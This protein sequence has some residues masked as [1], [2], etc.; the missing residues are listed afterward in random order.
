MIKKQRTQIDGLFILFNNIFYDLRGSFKKVFSH[1]IFDQLLLENS[2]TEIYYS[3]NK[4]HVIR[5]MHF[6]IPPMEHSKIVYV[7]SGRIL[8]VCLDLRIRSNSFNK[9][10]SIELSAND[11]SFLYIPKGIAHGFASFEDNT[12]VNYIQN[13]CYSPKHDLGIKYDSFGFDWPIKNPIVS[14]RDLSFPS[15]ADWDTVF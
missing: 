12:I 3:V 9:F 14:N 13:S 8:D 2:F 4:R 11:A 7:S 1:P 6:Q 15:M 10:F 5:G